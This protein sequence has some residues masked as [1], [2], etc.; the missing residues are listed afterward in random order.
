MVQKIEGSRNWDFTDCTCMFIYCFSSAIQI[1]VIATSTV[2]NYSYYDHNN[3]KVFFYIHY[4]DND[5]DHID[6]SDYGRDNNC[7]NNISML[8]K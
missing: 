4:N 2:I 1:N 6:N 7:C 8:T 3:D 5:A